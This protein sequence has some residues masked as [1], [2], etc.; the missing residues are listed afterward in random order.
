MGGRI[1]KGAAKDLQDSVDY[2]S[3]KIDELGGQ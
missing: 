2:L 3:G 1:G